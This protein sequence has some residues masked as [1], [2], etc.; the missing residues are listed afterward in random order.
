MREYY[1]YMLRCQ[2][3]SL[4]IGV[5]NDVQKRLEQHQQGSDPLSYTYSKRPVELVY[6]ESFRDVRDAIA[7]EKRMRGWSHEKKEALIQN[8]IRRLK[9]LSRRKKEMSH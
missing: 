4:Y 6:V 5:T 2:D 8:D 3:G 9:V 7:S 1:V